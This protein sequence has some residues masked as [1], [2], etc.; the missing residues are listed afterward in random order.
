M[1]T[2]TNIKQLSWVPSPGEHRISVNVAKV[3]DLKALWDFARLLG[4]APELVAL[5]RRDRLEVHLLLLQ[6]HLEPGTVL[7]LETGEQIERL[8]ILIP[9]HAIVHVFG[10]QMEIEEAA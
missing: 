10:G 1:T 2:L 7:G 6:E 9:A 4:F 3:P 8:E 5:Q